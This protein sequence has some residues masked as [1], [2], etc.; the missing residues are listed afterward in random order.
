MLCN[1]GCGTPNGGVGNVHVGGVRVGECQ[2]SS[3]VSKPMHGVGDGSSVESLLV[4][5]KLIW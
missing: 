5:G 3:G 2:T 4:I 1:I